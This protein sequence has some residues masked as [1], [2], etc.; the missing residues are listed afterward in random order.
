MA[1]LSVLWLDACENSSRAGIPLRALVC[2][3]A[4]PDF[5]RLVSARRDEPQFAPSARSACA[6]RPR[7]GSRRVALARDVRARGVSAASLGLSAR[8]PLPAMAG[9]SSAVRTVQPGR[10]ARCDGR[11]ILIA[12][13]P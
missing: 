4:S 11:A 1:P 7:G 6:T 5:V 10:D 12:R 2:D 8:V 3:L 9:G 13:H